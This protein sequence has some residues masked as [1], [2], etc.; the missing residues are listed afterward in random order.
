MD[1]ILDEDIKNFVSSFPF[2]EDLTGRKFLVTGA[3]GLIGS[4]LVKCL[5]ALDKDIQVTC[6][7][8]NMD[9]AMAVFGKDAS[10]LRFYEIINGDWGSLLC[11]ISEKIDYVVHCASPTSGSYM[12]EHPVETYELAFETTKLLLRYAKVANVRSFVY[13]SSVEYYGT[14]LE[15][16]ILT[17]D[18]QGCIDIT[19]PRS[20]Y[21]MGKR[22]A[23]YLCTAYAKEYGVKVKIARLTQTFGA[24][25]SKSD[26]RVFAQFARSI[27][28]KEDIVL[29]T[30]GESAKPYCYTTDSVSAILYILLKGTDCEAY[31][32]AAPETY[33]S[34]RGMAEMLCRRF[35]PDKCVRIDFHPEMGY[36]PVTKLHL[37]ADKLMELGW[38]PRYNLV[39]MFERLIEWFKQA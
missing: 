37:S 22:A 18:M 33:V 39:Q 10:K 14:V 20:S 36:A 35:A 13:V 17:E 31:N 2:S 9:K 15:D 24:G 27:M 19:S 16:C 5:L 6:L 3:T 29:H 38:T 23:E 11:S 4:T 32:V 34:V 28:K 8:R 26:N 25:V 1:K 12:V 21:P 30:T 7:V